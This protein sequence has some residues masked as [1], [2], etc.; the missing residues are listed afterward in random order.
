MAAILAGKG[1]TGDQNILESRLGFFRIFC[2]EGCY[3][4]EKVVDRLGRPFDIEKPGII[5]KKYP[6]CAFS[7]P[8]VDAALIISQD[9][10]YES[11]DVERVEGL[12][13]T[14]A[15]QILIHRRPQTGLEAKFS[16]E[17]CVSLAL[18]DGRLNT[19][20]FS[21]ERVR[22]R[23]MTDFM[24]RVERKVVNVD[25]ELAKEF[26]PATVKV[27]LK[28][29]T[30]LEATVQKARGNPENPMSLREIEEKYVDCCSGILSPDAIERSL[31][32]LHELDRLERIRTLTE[33]FRVS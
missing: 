3:D 27:F 22:G 25:G 33:C 18:L 4:G 17:G 23:D 30:V 31:A 2:G 12:I 5:L 6:S 21:D 13:H 16:L 26:G 11:S 20:S 24:S 14:L 8:A 19:S 32:M 15:D 10:A 1:W 29:G 7:H 28:G 9:P